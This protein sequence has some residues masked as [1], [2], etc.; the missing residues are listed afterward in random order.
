MYSASRPVCA[1]WAENNNAETGGIDP[2]R[3][4]PITKATMSKTINQ[5][6]R[7]NPFMQ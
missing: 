6:Q 2:M 1:G 3:R 4:T 7:L 5:C